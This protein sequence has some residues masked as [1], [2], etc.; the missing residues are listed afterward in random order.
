MRKSFAAVFV[1]VAALSAVSV[2]AAPRGRQQVGMRERNVP[3]LTRV[4]RMVKRMFGVK[5]E[6]EI[7]I[8]IPR[9]EAPENQNQTPTEPIS[10]PDQP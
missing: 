8:P 6:G 9:E 5:T 4:M 3:A 1:L 2:S 7:V 10:E